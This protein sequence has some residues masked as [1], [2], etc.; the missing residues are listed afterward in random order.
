MKSVAAMISGTVC[1]LDDLKSGF[2][3]VKK[4]H[5]QALQEAIMDLQEK[6]R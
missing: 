2:M 4:K 3:T 6:R 1:V 5:L